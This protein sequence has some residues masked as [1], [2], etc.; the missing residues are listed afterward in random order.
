L[1]L[2]IA[3]VLVAALVFLDLLGIAAVVV[4]V[5]AV[6]LMAYSHSGVLPA[7]LG[8]IAGLGAMALIGFAVFAGLDALTGDSAMAKRIRMFATEH[9]V[10][11]DN[12]VLGGL[13]AFFLLLVASGVSR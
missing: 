12:M 10:P 5:A 4:G 3:L 9:L 2:L 1:V 7:F 8:V 13:L 6:G 11:G